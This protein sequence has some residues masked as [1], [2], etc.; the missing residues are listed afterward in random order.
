MHPSTVYATSAF[1]ARTTFA[2]RAM[3]DTTLPMFCSFTAP[4]CHPMLQPPP[5]YGRSCASTSTRTDIPDERT[6]LYGRA[7]GHQS[8]LPGYPST[9][10]TSSTG[11]RI[12]THI[13]THTPTDTHSHMHTHVHAHACTSTH[14]NPHKHTHTH[15]HRHVHVHTYKHMHVRQ[16][17]YLMLRYELTLPT[18]KRRLLAIM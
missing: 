4:F 15:A 2:V 18:K 3:K 10:T 8:S 13:H 14:T 12:H 9:T 7:T 6:A 5:A 17:L 1:N 11:T 16:C